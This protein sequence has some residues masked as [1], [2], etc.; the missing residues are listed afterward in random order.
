MRFLKKKIARRALLRAERQP[1]ESKSETQPHSIKQES[2]TDSNASTSTPEDRKNSSNHSSEKEC[3]PNPTKGLCRN[4]GRA[5][6]SFALTPAALPYILQKDLITTTELWEGFRSFVRQV[7]RVVNGTDGLRAAVLRKQS[8]PGDIQIYKKSFQLLAEIFIK[9]YSISWITYSKR[10][11]L[12]MLHLK[13]RLKIL[14]LIQKPELYT[15][16]ALKR[17]RS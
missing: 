9:F 10:L 11:S 4:Y 3:K 8:D 7:R 13:Y 12:R 17:H 15:S 14:K 16:L 1:Q 5:I 6:A 2:I